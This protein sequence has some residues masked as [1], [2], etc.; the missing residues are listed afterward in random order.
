MSEQTAKSLGYLALG[1][2]GCVA[3]I[4]VLLKLSEVWQPPLPNYALA[5][6]LLA[7]II[8]GL[9]LR[10]GAKSQAV[11]FLLVAI[12]TVGSLAPV[13]KLGI[14]P[15]VVAVGLLLS[16][17][18][19][20]PKHRLAI[21][22]IYSGAIA[23]ALLYRENFA[24]S[25]TGLRLF[26]SLLVLP[27]PLSL[28]LDTQL[29]YERARLKA[30]AAL[31]GI[32]VVASL[33]LL[34]V[35]TPSLNW[36]ITLAIGLA[37]LAYFMRAKTVQ[38][39]LATAITVIASLVAFIN[40]QTV[41][42]VFTPLLPAYLLAVSL[43]FVNPLNGLAGGI[44][45]LASTAAGLSLTDAP[46]DVPLLMRVVATAFMTLVGLYLLGAIRSD[47]ET[48]SEPLMQMVKRFKIFSAIAIGVSAVAMTGLIIFGTLLQRQEAPLEVQK[49]DLHSLAHALIDRESNIR[50]FVI[51]QD[52]DFYAHFKDVGRKI[53]RE[54]ERLSVTMDPDSY[55][56]LTRL[57]RE[58]GQLYQREHNAV[59]RGDLGRASELVAKGSGQRYSA[60]LSRLI[61]QELSKIDGE[62]KQLHQKMFATNLAL[63]AS[64]VMALLFLLLL[65]QRQFRLF[66]R[67]VV[68]PIER[69]GIALTEFATSGNPQ[70]EPS[71]NAATEIQ[72]LIQRSA[73]MVANVSLSQKALELNA[74]KLEAAASVAGLGLFE[75]NSSTGELV[76]TDRLR[77]IYDVKHNGP[78]TIDDIWRAI[79]P[80]DAPWIEAHV[81]EHQSTLADGQVEHRLLIDGETRWIR[82]AGRYQKNRAD[83]VIS[84]VSVLDITDEKRRELELRETVKEL[85]ERR[86]KQTQ[87]FS[88]ISHELRTPLSSTKMIFDDIGIESLTGFGQMLRS[89]NNA[90]LGILDDLRMV[91]DPSK[92]RENTLS[93]AAPGALADQTLK[94]LNGVLKEHGVEA[95]LSYDSV[96]AK[97]MLFNVA[98]LRQIIT[99]LVKNAALHSQGHN[100]WVTLT[101]VEDELKR[102]SITL[103]IEDDGKGIPDSQKEAL[104][105][106]FSRGDTQADGT[107]LGLF[108]IR[109][110]ATLMGCELSCFD[111]KHGGVGFKFSCTLDLFSQ[112]TVPDSEAKYSPTLL[113]AALKEKRILFAEDQLTIQMLSKGMLQKAGASVT[114]CNNG[115]E[116]M[117]AYAVDQF[118]LVLTDAMMPEMDGYQL[119]RALRSA[120]YTGPIFAVTAAT[121]GDESERLL[122]SGADVVLAK[123]LEMDLLKRTVLAWES[124][125]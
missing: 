26:M 28:L 35:V 20:A 91:I 94:S 107:G 4:L 111:S 122:E 52:P 62:I 57:I 46:I 61:N 65:A 17:M 14:Y 84:T 11:R 16:V 78:M 112:L 22:F 21:G 12:F 101:G 40:A 45:V 115:L 114:V 110:L 31:V 79:H 117:R 90:V 82:A 56:A 99:N 23:L 13:A 48:K 118:D 69:L 123:P 113:R 72:T 98:A 15:S 8:A 121:I 124:A 75:F 3:V 33:M 116:A 93:E 58:R 47:R 92:V 76:A 73:G 25:D 18:A 102:A 6:P 55:T 32:G 120:G 66:Q 38:P 9:L 68:D 30:F 59:M 74:Q 51:A 5:I 37:L 7:I 19:L 86:D 39:S 44:L 85:K 87:M 29:P 43:L 42:T 106:P 104:F 1:A 24:L 60:E 81:S 34:A 83:E 41:A 53:D 95:H 105:E 54:L 36:W 89:N 100:V 97:Q 49:R 96:A 71:A 108:I 50:G 125:Q 80:E 27:Y 109:E 77:D 63:N 2:G 67:S 88:I 103:R 64:I 10:Y 119:C 70:I